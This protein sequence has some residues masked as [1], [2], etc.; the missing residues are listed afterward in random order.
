MLCRQIAFRSAQ[1]CLLTNRI[2]QGEVYAGR[3][4]D[5]A[6]IALL[7]TLTNSQRRDLVCLGLDPV[8]YAKTPNLREY[9]TQIEGE[10]A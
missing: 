1:I 3:E 8:D 5:P 4:A 7:N 2:G 6:D 9:L 10:A